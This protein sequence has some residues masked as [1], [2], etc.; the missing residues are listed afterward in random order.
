MRCYERW[1]YRYFG[2]HTVATDVLDPHDSIYPRATTRLGQKFQANLVTWEQ[3]KEMGLGVALGVDADQINAE[4]TPV[5]LTRKPRAKQKRGVTARKEDKPP[6]PA[7]QGQPTPEG[8]PALTTAALPDLDAVTAAVR[9]STTPALVAPVREFERGGDESVEV[10]CDVSSSP[11]EVREVRINY[12][13]AYMATAAYHFRP[14]PSYNVDFIDHAVKVYND[15]QYEPIVALQ[16]VSKSNSDDLRIMHWTEKERRA[17][18]QAIKD[19]GAEMRQ[20]KKAIPTKT[21]AEI[22]RYFAIWKNARLQD[23]HATELASSQNSSG[24]GSSQGAA[25][26][27]QSSSQPAANTRAVSPALS[28]WDGPTVK[29][30]PNVSCKVCGTTTSSKWYRGAFVWPNRNMCSVC[31]IYWR[32]YAAEPPVNTELIATNPRKH[33]LPAEEHAAVSGPPS[34]AAKFSKTATAGAGM[35]SSSTAAAAAAVAAAAKAALAPAAPVKPD[36]IRCVMCKRL[37]PKKK[38]QQCLH[39]SLSVH[40]GCFGLS[41]EEAASDKWVCDPCSNEQSLDNALHPHCILCPSPIR[42]QN[43]TACNAAGANGKSSSSTGAASGAAFSRVGRGRPS[44]VSGSKA[45]PVAA[46]VGEPLTALD[47]VKPT[48]CNNWA[49]L[50]CAAWIPEVMVTD[51]VAMKPVEGAGY[52]PFWRYMSECEICRMTAGAC[53]QCSEP[54]CKRTFHVSCALAQNTGSLRFEINPVKLSRRDSVTTASFKSETGHWTCLAFC[55]GH[56]DSFKDKPLTYDFFETDPKTGLTA[57]QVY[58]RTHKSVNPASLSSSSQGT[59]AAAVSNGHGGHGDQMHA[60]LRRA[61]RFDTVLSEVQQE[62]RRG[63]SESHRRAQTTKTPPAPPS[64]SIGRKT[65]TPSPRTGSKSGAA[66]SPK[67][68]NNGGEGE[69]EVQRGNAKA[70]SAKPEG[71]KHCIR[72]DIRFSPFWWPVEAG[73]GIEKIHGG[74]GTVIAESGALSCNLCRPVVFPAPE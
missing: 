47:A 43:T 64:I 73:R 25:D 32:K 33:P 4:E 58:M 48:E 15:K 65:A 41:D 18:E 39:C 66:G 6:L 23:Q 29:A 61:K 45:D 55:K 30:S 62:A 54:L 7:T 53:I 8:T 27:E 26:G 68:T 59:S 22:V 34:K 31:G 5:A 51:G 40:Q 57:L 46:S 16:E 35:T 17:F 14:H 10:I 56:K 37:E 71:T 50:I 72:C 63:P 9:D 13:D 74:I 69:E 49:H 70:A 67:A 11:D 42:P 21:P 28:V 1:P 19:A 12:L 38:L 52:L 36:P 3:Q 24:N 60:L 2:Q 20:L 44:A